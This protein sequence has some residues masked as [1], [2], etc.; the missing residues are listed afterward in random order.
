[1]KINSYKTKYNINESIDIKT[2]HCDFEIGLFNTVRAA[3]LSY[4]VKLC[5]FHFRQS[6]ERKRKQYNYLF[7][8]FISWDN[9]IFTPSC[10]PPKRVDAFGCLV[11][12]FDQLKSYSDLNY[13]SNLNGH[14]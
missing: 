13:N 4:K 2:I 7:M 14:V 10:V 11:C 1:M 5:L 8:S 3:G 6:I 12:E 9:Y